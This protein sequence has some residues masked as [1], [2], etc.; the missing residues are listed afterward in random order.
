MAAC[1]GSNRQNRDAWFT[2]CPSAGK[3][4]LMNIAV[5]RHLRPPKELQTFFDNLPLIGSERP[6]DYH[7]LFSAVASAE[8]PSDTIDWILLRDLV[9]LTWEIRRERRI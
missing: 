2:S 7:A 6:Q 8:M 9:D 4:R 1:G 3:A 5:T